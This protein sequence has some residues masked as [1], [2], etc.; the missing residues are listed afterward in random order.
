MLDTYGIIMVLRLITG[1][2]DLT[3]FAPCY[4]IQQ[5]ALLACDESQQPSRRNRAGFVLESSNMDEGRWVSTTKGQRVLV[6]IED[7][8]RVMRHKWCAHSKGYAQRRGS[9][10]TRVDRK[11]IY[12][13]RWLV[14][15]PDGVQV[16][17]E[18]RCKWDCRRSNL[19]IA[20][21]AQNQQNM[22][23]SRANTSGYK[24][25]YWDASHGRWAVEIVANC[26]K[27]RLGRFHDPIMGARA[28]DRKA[29]ELHGE[30]ARTNFPMEDYR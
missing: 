12:L 1:A 23:I 17:H 13:H 28:Y 19:R 18:N 15:A 21:P 11:I 7:Y 3:T 29:I 25:V 16:D 30:F 24:G 2:S 5:P 20:T 14:N 27:H 6:S 10:V 9:G 8:D 22:D 4:T 26:R